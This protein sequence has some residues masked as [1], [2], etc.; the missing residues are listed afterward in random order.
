ETDQLIARVEKRL[1]QA[2]A[3]RRLKLSAEL[4][5]DV[6]KKRIPLA[7][8]RRGAAGQRQRRHSQLAFRI[9]RQGGGGDRQPRKQRQR[10]RQ[11]RFFMESKNFHAFAARTKRY[12]KSA[13]QWAHLLALSGIVERQCGQSL[14]VGAAAGAGFGA[15]SA[16]ICR[17]IRNSTKAMIRKLIT[18]LMKRP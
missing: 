11:T 3:Q 6:G 2:I 16:L 9:E 4:F 1:A 12:F 13:V 5:N 7:P 18:A 17:M 15:V 14:V 8:I 10:A